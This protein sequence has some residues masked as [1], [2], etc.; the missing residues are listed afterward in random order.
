[1]PKQ[2]L[3]PDTRIGIALI[4]FIFAL[5]G[6]G[7]GL[8]APFF[9]QKNVGQC[10][11]EAM[12]CPDGNF[13]SRSGPYCTFTPCTSTTPS[14]QG[15]ITEEPFQLPVEKTPTKEKTA[16]K[17]A[18]SEPTK[19][20]VV[21]PQDAKMCSDGSFVSRTGPQCAFAPCPVSK[22][23]SKTGRGMNL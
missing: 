16:P 21:C 5:I 12:L 3:H 23:V 11:Q 9:A 18:P 4:L 15:N 20:E 8:S 17:T 1:M 13:V 6:A 2:T 10:P 19:K 14:L 7:V 22:D